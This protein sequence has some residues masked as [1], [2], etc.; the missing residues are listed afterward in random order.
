MDYPN[1]LSLLYNDLGG[2]MDTADKIGLFLIAL[3]IAIGSFGFGF[4]ISTELM[5]AQAVDAN[6]AYYEATKYG[7]I[8]FK[9]VKLER[10]CYVSTD[11]SK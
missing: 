2:K 7:N 8:E 9:W 3:L 1:R 5:R 10:G 6:V 11:D 4:S